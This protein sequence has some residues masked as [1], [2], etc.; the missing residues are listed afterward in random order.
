MLDRVQQGEPKAA[1]ELLPIIY[2]E[3]RR[4]AA[5]KLAN[6]APGQTLKPTALVHEAWLRL[7][8]RCT[9]LMAPTASFQAR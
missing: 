7:V 9:H 4:L 1:E 5:H 8:G 3:L 2:D 6:E